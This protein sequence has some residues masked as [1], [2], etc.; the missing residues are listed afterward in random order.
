L[1]G[2]ESVCQKPEVAYPDEAFGQY[3]EKETPQELRPQERHLSL[4]ASVGVVFPPECH[5]LT[6]KS[7]EPMVGNG[8]PMRI[9]AQVTQNLRGTAEGGFGINHPVLPM[10][11]A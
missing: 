4:L 1:G 2:A 8:D 5:A 3:V 6:V 7:Q 11:P 10:Q 9:A